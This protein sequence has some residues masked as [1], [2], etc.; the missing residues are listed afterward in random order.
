MKKISSLF[1]L[2]L[3]LLVLVSCDNKE[4][5]SQEA[6][7]P[8][9]NNSQE[10][11][12]P[13]GNN[14]QE[15][16]NP[17]GNNPESEEI[18]TQQKTILNRS[19]ELAEN[20]ENLPTAEDINKTLDEEIIKLTSNEQSD[21]IDLSKKP[22]DY[23]MDYYSS[24]V[25]QYASIDG[26]VNMYK[27]IKDHVLSVVR[28]LNKWITDDIYDYKLSYN[29]EMDV[30]TIEQRKIF[31]DGE[32][33]S[34]SYSKITSGYNNQNKMVIKATG[35]SYDYNFNTV[36]SHA[37]EFEEDSLWTYIYHQGRKVGSAQN[38]IDLYHKYIVQ[39]DLKSEDH[40]YTIYDK[41]KSGKNSIDTKLILM[42]NEDNH[43]YITNYNDDEGLVINRTYDVYDEYG[44][45]VANKEW[46]VDLDGKKYSQYRISLYSLEGWDECYLKTEY[47]GDTPYDRIHIIVNSKNLDITGKTMEIDE[48]NQTSINTT[49]YTRY[50]TS[51][52]IKPALVISSYDKEHELEDI[53]EYL[54]LSLKDVD[55]DIDSYDDKIAN[56]SAFDFDNICGKTDE[57]YT[58]LY[59][60]NADEFELITDESEILSTLDDVF[61][62]NAIKIN[63]QK[64][65]SEIYELIGAEITGEIT[66]NDD[67][68]IDLSDIK[69]N[70]S[71]NAL[72]DV[73]SLYTLSV[74]LKSKNSICDI[75]SVSAI[76]DNNDFIIEGFLNDYQIP[77]KLLSNVEYS[78]VAYVRKDNP[79]IRISDT[80]TLKSSDETKN[81]SFV[82]NQNEILEENSTKGIYNTTKGITISIINK[83]ITVE[84]V[85]LEY[86]IS[87]PQMK[88]KDEIE[89][90]DGHIISAED[91]F[92]F[93]SSSLPR[94][95]IYL[96]KFYAI[97]KSSRATTKKI[98]LGETK[99][100]LYHEKDSDFVLDCNLDLASDLYDTEYYYNLSY[101]LYLVED[102]NYYLLESNNFNPNNSVYNE[103]SYE[104]ETCI[105][106]GILRTD[107]N[108]LKI[109]VSYEEKN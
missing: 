13:N 101:E 60:K 22:D 102:D 43:Y 106:H 37:L 95:Q 17:N 35:I 63:E 103:I 11:A 36:Y 75:G 1:M 105:L 68:T 15:P 70:I 72:L 26:Q 77:I 21:V 32:Y 56:W 14:S 82:T 100:K 24:Y 73:G 30:V 38:G 5:I 40:K 41:E 39:A 69:A 84:Y 93:D 49:K 9:E 2:L 96:I 79:S 4:N 99:K 33:L 78:F 65:E 31:S 25:F 27:Q 50:S 109:E 86:K 98:L 12:N 91:C 88:I 45:L 3:M 47:E 107:S 74:L 42:F 46:F 92:E 89:L 7:N 108:G 85:S 48:F 28:E 20:I 62:E 81:L 66:I 83:N 29:R 10:P 76:Y 52:D 58:Y 67:G 6:A 87:L 71:K 54:G 59:Q 23:G 61:V 51:A 34:K 18:L 97:A 64:K 16:A 80:K 94:N 90:I 53:L 55:L 8:N 104:Y 44:G 19:F 57:E